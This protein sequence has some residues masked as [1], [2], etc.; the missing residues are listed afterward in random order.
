MQYGSIQGPIRP[1]S[2][3]VNKWKDKLEKQEQ[4]KLAIKSE[5]V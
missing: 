2:E 5:W 3:N 1:S 4:R